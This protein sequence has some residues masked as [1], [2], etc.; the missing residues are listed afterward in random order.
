M[1]GKLQ[2]IKRYPNYGISKFDYYRVSLYV[3]GMTRRD[4]Y[5][6]ACLQGRDRSTNLEE[7][8]R[9][10]GRSARTFPGG[11]WRLNRMSAQ[12]IRDAIAD[13]E[14]VLLVTETDAGAREDSAASDT[15]ERLLRAAG[16]RSRR[17]SFLDFFKEILSGK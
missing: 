1:F 5:V 11:K 12:E 2:F 14:E 13:D 17:G 10:A 9:Q 7:I 8:A 16:R 6:Y 3:S 15:S 4:R